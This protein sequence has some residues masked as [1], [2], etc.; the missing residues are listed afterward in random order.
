M[1]GFFLIGAPRMTMIIFGIE[2]PC[3]S[4]SICAKKYTNFGL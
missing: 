4:S 1:F 3:S 2:N